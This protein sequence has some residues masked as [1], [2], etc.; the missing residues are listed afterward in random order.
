VRLKS[1]IV[2]VFCFITSI[3][4]DVNP[5]ILETNP[6]PL[7]GKIIHSSLTS[8]E[9]IMYDNSSTPRRL[10]KKAQDSTVTYS[11]YT[12]MNQKDLLI[13]TES[14]TDSIRSESK[15]NIIKVDLNGRITK[16]LYEAKKGELV[17]PLYTSLDDKYLL[18]TSEYLADPNIYP[19]EGLSPMVSLVI[20]DLNNEQIIIKIDS[21]GRLPNLKVEE[22]PWLHDGYKFVYSLGD[23]F[24]LKTNDTL[25]NQTNEKKGIYLYD[26]K[27]ETN[28]L[29]IPEGQ[30]AIV[31]PNDNR[32]AFERDNFIS[33]LNFDTGEEKSIYEYSDNMIIYS[34]HWTPDGKHIFFTYK[35]KWGFD[36]F[37]FEDE[38]LIDIN[39]GKEVAFKKLGLG[40]SMYS[41]K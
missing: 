20:M 36:Y 14:I 30:S 12:W 26:V 19:F 17:W 39:S 2:W 8:D 25:V 5:T 4:C 13:G 31:A 11:G 37:Y 40:Y 16:K 38:K 15:C 35:Y 28:K 27:L 41:W 1:K 24:M 9:Y 22:S 18:F 10:F 23:H 21:I 33:V 29:I 6:K 34:K 7:P 32:I 3:S